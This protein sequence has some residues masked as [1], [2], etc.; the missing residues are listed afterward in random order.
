M[1]A[2]QMDEEK[3]K[4]EL[5]KIDLYVFAVD[6]EL[7][8][9]T[10]LLRRM[11]R[12]REGH[13]NESVAQDKYYKPALEIYKELKKGPIRN[14]QII[15]RSEIRQIMPPPFR[16][17]IGFAGNTVPKRGYCTSLHKKIRG[18]IQIII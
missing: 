2:L 12:Q 11:L 15:G 8:P 16:M 13:W 9:S 5:A 14:I 18:L 3:A 17:M 10:D 4:Q 6:R 7:P 1:T